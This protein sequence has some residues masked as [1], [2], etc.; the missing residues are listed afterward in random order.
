MDERAKQL[1]REYQRQY[2]EKNR[3]KINAQKREWMAKNKDKV[4]QQKREW[5]KANPDKER[6]YKERHWQRKAE[7]LGPMCMN[8]GQSFEPKRSDAKFCSTRCRVAHSRK[9]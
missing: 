7:E 4:N 2:R 3:D 1:R 8:C 9:R 6:L 5:R